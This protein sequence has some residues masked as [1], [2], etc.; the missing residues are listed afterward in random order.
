MAADAFRAA[1]AA[2]VNLAGGHDGLGGGRAAD[3]AC[4]RLRAV[5]IRVGTCSWADESL[6]SCWYPPGV[7][8]SARSGCATYAQHFDTVEV[9]SS[10]YA[11]PAAPMAAAW[12][13]RTPPGFLFHV[14]AFG[15][16]TRHP[17]KVE[18]LP[19]DM[20]GEVE[21]WMPADASS[22]R[23][24]SC[25][26]SVFARFLREI[27]PMRG[28]RQAGRHPDAVARRTSCTGRR[29]SST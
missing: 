15:M 9:N 1:G 2:A 29:R 18:Q 12:A 25:G 6:A 8:S 24:G 27:D 16:M 19:P 17:V 22:G 21:S 13:D 10:Y 14:K 11:L 5:S 4:G 23:P 28:G 3:R 26:P 7:K 20:R